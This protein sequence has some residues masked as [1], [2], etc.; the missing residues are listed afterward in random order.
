M[1]DDNER[2]QLKI[3][4]TAQAREALD[5]AASA[6]GFLSANALVAAVANELAGVPACK[7]WEVLAEVRRYHP[8]SREGG[9]P[10]K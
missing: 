1:N 7:V 9:R 2:E 4:L 10:R 3:R 6:L 8:G 5:S